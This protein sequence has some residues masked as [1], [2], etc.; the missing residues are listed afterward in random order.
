M[1]EQSMKIAICDDEPQDRALVAALAGE[2]AEQE[3]IA[4]EFFHY[5]DGT[6]LLR[7]LQNGAQYHVLLLDVMMEGINGM[8][9]A[10]MVRKSDMQT[11]I[12]FISNNRELALRG[13]E[14][15]AVRY[16]AKPLDC[17]KLREALLYCYRAAFNRQEIAL[18]TSRGTRRIVLSD[19]IYAETWGRGV[20]LNLVDG[21]EEVNV[22]ISELE[23]MLPRRQFVICHRAFLVN[24]AYVQ[25]LRYCE[26]ELKTGGTL[27]VSKYRQ[28]A[29]RER[30]INYLEG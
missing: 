12:V 16:L 23:E 17:E 6:S 27:P 9:L 26:L 15:S 2:I 3:H 1:E 30:L 14:V 11:A 25:Y 8:D 10:E 19:L 20:R 4:C 7:A 22:K 5:A 24:L 28:S 29:T 21:Q 18:P 13:Y